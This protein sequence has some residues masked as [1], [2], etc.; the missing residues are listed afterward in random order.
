MNKSHSL[1]ASRAGFTLIELL[2]VIAIIAILAAMLLPALAAAKSKAYATQC[3]SNNKQLVL[4]WI[5]Y[6]SDNTDAMM[7][8]SPSTSPGESWIGNLTE[9][10]WSGVD[11]NTNASLYRT[12]LMAS[13]MSSQ[14]GVYRCP[15]DIVPSDNGQRIRSYSMQGQVGNINGGIAIDATYNPNA[16]I[17]S[18]V[19]DAYGALGASDLL[20]FLEENGCDLGNASGMDGYLEVNNAYGSTAGSYSG[21]ATFPDVPGSYH[22]WGV[23][24]CYADGH[25]E[26][27]HWV[28]S[29]L[30]LPVT[31]G[32]SGQNIAAGGLPPSPKV[33]ADWYWFT[34]HCAVHN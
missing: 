22:K 30:K 12:N 24:V 16:K 25:A 14:L 34:S 29:V 20:V 15:A 13:Y 11:A 4:G 31:Y 1:P 18:K 19:T 7:P 2:V 6:A 33:N 5:M 23:G 21:S 3:I 32:C 28:T 26:V 17:Y 10:R 9:Q 27:H 8:N